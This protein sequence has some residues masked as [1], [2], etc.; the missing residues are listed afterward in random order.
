MANSGNNGPMFI[1]KQ[2]IGTTLVRGVITRGLGF[3]VTKQSNLLTV[4]KIWAWSIVDIL[5]EHHIRTVTYYIMWSNFY[6][7][8]KLG[9]LVDLCKSQVLLSHIDYG[10]GGCI[11]CREYKKYHTCM[12]YSNNIFVRPQ[13]CRWLT[14]YSGAPIWCFANIH[15]FL[16]LDQ[17]ILALVLSLKGLTI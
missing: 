4:Q 16:Q 14:P 1:I 3:D 15:Y 8:V 9:A 12:H 5:Y 13:F 17:L 6:S 11:L 2:L 10:G 7:S